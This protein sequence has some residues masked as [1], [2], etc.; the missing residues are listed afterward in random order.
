M[1]T[2][3][4]GPSYSIAS[5]VVEAA[6]RLAATPSSD[7]DHAKKR[8]AGRALLTA[9]VMAFRNLPDGVEK[10]KYGQGLEIVLGFY[11][12]SAIQAV[13]AVGEFVTEQINLSVG[14][15]PTGIQLDMRLLSGDANWLGS[16]LSWPS[17]LPRTHLD[18]APDRRSRGWVTDHGGIVYV[19]GRRLRYRIGIDHANENPDFFWWTT[20]QTEEWISRV[21]H[22]NGFQEL[23]WSA[24]KT[25][26][27]AVSELAH[28]LFSYVGDYDPLYND[29]D[30]WGLVDLERDPITVRTVGPYTADAETHSDVSRTLA[31]AGD[32]LSVVSDRVARSERDAS[33]PAQPY[34]DYMESLLSDP[35]LLA[36]RETDVLVV[37]RGGVDRQR[38]PLDPED[39][40]RMLDAADKLVD[41]GIEVGFGFGH[42]ETSVHETAARTPNV[43]V[44]EA[45]TPTAAASW[46][47]K[48]HVNQRLVDRV[49]DPGQPR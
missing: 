18:L 40:R 28:D 22:G 25:F 47:L 46:V 9:E 34:A 7:G 44:F 48:E 1:I 10:K 12:Q 24:R 33:N 17:D 31:R 20:P 14:G 27:R 5:C 29:P 8:S 42:G 23:D 43:G 38:K 13:E 32:Q 30:D 41:Q 19:I 21:L 11:D 49:V 16:Q 36:R 45:I 39:C 26:N 2:Q 35:D 3:L 37:Y 15:A 4:E 6:R